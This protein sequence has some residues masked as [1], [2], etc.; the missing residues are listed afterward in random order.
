M[1]KILAN[2]SLH[3][4]SHLQNY[5]YIVLYTDFRF[6]VDYPAVVEKKNMFLSEIFSLLKKTNKTFFT[7]SYSYTTGGRFDIESTPTNVSAFSKWLVG[8][9]DT[10]RSAH[11][12]FSYVGL[13]KDTSLLSDIGKSAFGYNSIYY[14]LRNKNAGFLHLGREVYLGNTIIHYVEHMAGA[15]YRFHKNFKTDVF[16]NGAYIGTNYSAFVR[17]RDVAGHDF[18]FNFKNCAKALFDNKLITETNGV[19]DTP[20]L[21]SYSLDKSC[22]MM[23]E[24]FEKNESI[25]LNK[26]FEQDQGA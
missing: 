10:K 8:N 18:S 20:Y 24:M 7:P 19:S 9:K 16:D 25:F 6:L 14:K 2:L 15:P 4:E 21:A 13:G 22:D 23:L 12:I 17:R 5:N 11:P 26:K 1:E 3:L